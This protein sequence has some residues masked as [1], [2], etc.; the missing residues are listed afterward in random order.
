MKSISKFERICN[1]S[2]LNHG[3]TSTGQVSAQ[4]YHN[5][6]SYFQKVNCA[7]IWLIFRPSLAKI[8]SKIDKFERISNC[9]DIN[10]RNT[11]TDQFSAQIYP[12][13]WSYCQK[14]IFAPNLAHIWTFPGPNCVQNSQIWRSI[15]IF[16]IIPWRYKYKFWKNVFISWC[17]P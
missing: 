10:H 3:N 1:F 5:W 14:C 2:D 13:W 9:S 16:W 17:I 11:C 7:Q 8:V 12:N 6:W 15:L 4:N